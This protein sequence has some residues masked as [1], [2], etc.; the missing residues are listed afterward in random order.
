MGRVG[1]KVKG[2]AAVALVCDYRKPIWK[3]NAQWAHGSGWSRQ[4]K[5]F[6]KNYNVEMLG[7]LFP[8]A[9]SGTVWVLAR[10]VWAWEKGR[11]WLYKF[12]Y[13]KSPST[14]LLVLYLPY[15]KKHLKTNWVIKPGRNQFKRCVVSVCGMD[16]LWDYPGRQFLLLLEYIQSP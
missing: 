13:K 1:G 12:I 14:I 16:N 11:V 15:M 9:I 5:F 2:Q 4:L 6:S 10:F 3:G 7:L 8:L